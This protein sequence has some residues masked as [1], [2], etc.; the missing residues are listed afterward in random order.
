MQPSL[1]VAL[2]QLGPP[3]SDETQLDNDLTSSWSHE[4]KWEGYTDITTEPV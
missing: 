3:N 1:L 4:H 2:C